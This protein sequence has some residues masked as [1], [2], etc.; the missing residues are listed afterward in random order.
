MSKRRKESLEAA[1]TEMHARKAYM[2]NLFSAVSSEHIMSFQWPTRPHMQMAGKGA[3][4]TAH[5]SSLPRPQTPVKQFTESGRAVEA[6]DASF[7]L[8]S[9]DDIMRASIHLDGIQQARALAKGEAQRHLGPAF[10]NR[11]STP[12][13]LESALK[14]KLKGSAPTK[15]SRSSSTAIG[16]GVFL[17]SVAGKSNNVFKITTSTGKT[18]FLPPA[19]EPKHVEFLDGHEIYKW[20]QEQLLRIAFTR[21][22]FSREGTLSLANVANVANKVDVQALLRF[23]VFG[24]L[25]KR[26]RWAHFLSLVSM[27][28]N[29]SSAGGAV[30][31]S[32]WMAAARSVALEDNVPPKWVRSDMEHRRIILS[33]HESANPV[34]S[35][36]LSSG[37]FIETTRDAKMYAMLFASQSRSRLWSSERDAALRLQVSVG[38]VAWGLHGGGVVWLPAVVERI[39][40]DGTF[41]LS[42]PLS[43][44]SLQRL[45]EV[46]RARKLLGESSR[47]SLP[48]R[49]ALGIEN[50]EESLWWDG[51]YDAISRRSTM[52]SAQNM[53]QSMCSV[54]EVQALSAFSFVLSKLTVPAIGVPTEGNDGVASTEE[55]RLMSPLGDSFFAALDSIGD[56]SGQKHEHG[57]G[58]REFMAMCRAVADLS[59]YNLIQIRG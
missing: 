30:T 49:S 41:A 23:T 16:G 44:R 10:R 47:L 43:Q 17:T 20:D 12:G 11:S 5:V 29:S 39:N 18:V 19:P 46:Y 2:R 3:A 13:L 53:K 50:P 26:K 25:L 15:N 56:G 52:P 38:D 40:A 59:A 32:G 9:P 36:L 28:S 55:A 27:K 4:E 51:V 54:D 6:S 58:R 37:G 48:V 7:A 34:W 57:V 1:L 21:L 22:D 35:H 31:L 33:T 14:V 8:P 45:K 42:Y 24:S